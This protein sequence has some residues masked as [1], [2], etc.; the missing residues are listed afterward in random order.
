[1]SHIDSDG[2][3]WDPLLLDEREGVLKLSAE[4]RSNALS[5]FDYNLNSP[6]IRDDLDNL[7]MRYMGHPVGGLWSQKDW[8]G[9]LT[10]LYHRNAEPRA[11]SDMHKWFGEWIRSRDHPV[12]QGAEFLKRVDEESEITYDVVQAFLR[13]WAGVE[14]SIRRKSGEP[15][16]MC[17]SL[18]QK[19]LDLHKMV[20]YLNASTETERDALRRTLGLK[21]KKGFTSG[22]FISLGRVFFEKG[23]CW[24]E[25]QR[26]VMDRNFIL[27][28]KDVIVGRL[29]TVL[30][31]IGHENPV[32]SDG[33]IK[34]FTQIY[35]IGDSILAELGNEAYDLI[36]CIEPICNLRLSELAH[37][38]RPLIPL[39]PRFHQHISDSVDSLAVRST[40]I[41]A[42]HRAIMDLQ[43]VD[44]V[45]AVYGSFRHW[46]HP[47][48][49]YTEGLRKLHEQVTM[50][51]VIDHAYA[52]ALASDLARI[53]LEQE[54]NKKKKW[55]VNPAS[56]SL[57]HPFRTHILENTWPTPAQI[58]DFGDHWHELPLIQCFDIP[59]LIDPS[60]IYSDK[61]H[62]MNRAEVLNHVR[63]HPNKIIPTKKVLKTM[64]EKPATNWLEFLDEI[65]RN[66]LGEDDLVIGLKGKERE[67]KLIGRFFSL[68]SWKLREYFVITE[69]LIKTHFVPLFHGLTMADD[70]TSVIKKMMDS[71]S[72]QGLTDY[73]AVCIANHIDYEKWNNHQRKESNGPVFRVMGQFLGF[74]NLISRTHEFFEKS[75]VYYN[76]RPDLMRVSGNSLTNTTNLRVCWEGQAGGLEGLRQKGWSILNLLVIQREAKIRNTS[77]KVLAQGDNQVICTQYKTRNHRDS[78][79][80][81]SALQDIQSNNDAIMS[82][83]ERGTTKL[84]LVI[85][86]DETMQSA[87]YLNYGKIPIFR[88]T[89]RGLEF[90]RWSRVTCVTNDQLPT[91]ANLMSSVSTNALTVAHFDTNPTNAM[92]QF[93]YFGNFARLLLYMH[94]PAIKLSFHD[95]KFSLK[96]VFS[97]AFKIGML[98][99]DPSIGGVCGTALSRFLIRSFPD[100]VTESLA[101]WKLIYHNTGKKELRVLAARFGNPRIAVFRLE[102]VD[103]LL[104][105]PTSLNISM[106]MSPANLLKTEIKKNL[107]ENKGR[108]KNQIV[109]DSV[110]R[111][112]KDDKHL[113]DFLW[114]IDPLFPRFLSEFKSGTFA[115]VASSIVSLFQNSRTVRNLFKEF[116]S[117]EL[118]ILVWRSEISSLEHLVS[119][120]IRRDTPAIWSCSASQADY[121]RTLS[122][123]RKCLGTTVPH[124]LEMHGRGDIKSILNECCRT[125]SMD[126]ISVYCPKGLTDVLSGR[127]PFPA[128]LGSKTS[129]ST[130]I[131]QPWEKESKVPLIRRATRL[132]DA[133]HWFI[134]PKSNL[135]SAINDN[136]SSLTGEDWSQAAPG[137]KRTGSALHRFSTSRMSNGGFA[138]QSPAA[139]TRMV[140][141]TDTMI[142]FNQEN[143][144]FMFQ[145]SLLYSQMST[146]VMLRD[147]GIS[148]TVHFH[149]K[150]RDC[151]RKIEEPWLETASAYKFDNM[152]TTLNEWRNGTGS[153]GERREQ[154]PLQNGDWES[155]TPAEKSYHVGRAVGFLYGELANQNSKHSDDSSIFPLSIQKKLRGHSFFKGMLDGLM[156]ASACQVIHRRS[157]AQIKRPANAVYGGLIY[158]IDKLSLSHPFVN[159]CREGQL[160]EELRSIPHKIPASYPTSNIDLGVNIRNY[161]RYH[162]A[163][164]SRGIYKIEVPQIWVFSDLMSLDFVGPFALSGKL[165]KVLYKP[166]LSKKDRNSIRRINNL[167]KLLRSNENLPDV[168]QNYIKERVKCC[169]EEIRHACKFGIPPTLS[170]TDYK[171]WGDEDYGRCYP[172]RV[173]FS[174]Q[175]STKKLTMPQRIQNPIVSGLRTAQL[176]TGAHYKLR[177]IIKHFVIRYSH[178]I[179]G[180]DG[181][182]GMTAALLRMNRQSLGIFNSLLDYSASTMRG[183][184]PDPP[185][186]LETLGGE[187]HRCINGDTVWEAPSDLSET[188]TWQYFH[189]LKSE[190]RLSIDLMV[191]DMEVQDPNT[192]ALI[193]QR[194][195]ENL[196][197]L[198][199]PRGTLIYKTYGTMIARQEKGALETFGPLFQDVH[200]T[201]TEYSSAE[202]S[203]VYLVCRGLKGF[204]DAKEVDW[205]DLAYH[206]GKLRCFAGADSEYDRAKSISRRDGMVGVPKEFLPDPIAS[207]GTLMEIAGVP[208]GV[209]HNL[210]ID[211]DMAPVSGLSKA[212]ALCIMLSHHT[213]NTLR[214]QPALPNPPS[215]G[216]VINLGSALCGIGLW[217]SLFYNDKRLYHTC[218]QC[219]RVC[220]PFRCRTLKLKNGKY[221]MEWGVREQLRINKD[222][223]LCD[224]MA[225]IGQWIRCLSRLRWQEG[226]LEVSWVNAFLSGVSAG[227]TVIQTKN[228]TGVFDF[229]KG[230][231]SKEDHSRTLV[232][233]ET[234]DSRDWRE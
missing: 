138:S 183:S 52:N 202:T 161:F 154:V 134:D 219:I 223:R 92:T 31:M 234:I 122:W 114:S 150:C 18:C 116:M 229:L 199:D 174:S 118:D 166:A 136:L 37:S 132:R 73:S 130:S 133:I 46:G 30:A 137:F 184:A 81:H 11:V 12:D 178:F 117:K 67:L 71:S 108:I 119:Y 188:S 220:F 123:K 77:V 90:K 213:V 142:E 85:N 47:F 209:A 63:K 61:S 65:D 214:E 53:V 111:V 16:Y 64:L 176:P 170:G 41:R 24:L 149:V 160:R 98:Y 177:S 171:D 59:D 175:T 156:R 15:M 50:P 208:S 163:R 49:D 233:K 164:V 228:T 230:N 72:G 120:G 76:G 190:R 135:A 144:D 197:T 140:A 27:M 75:L 1:M 210:S 232:T 212:I 221:R 32:W 189:A 62:S 69:H 107:I 172:I 145:A 217:V 84:G 207:L 78:I 4:E 126:Y 146:S 40:R 162:C 181:S 56:V 157:L 80:L 179:C 66:G 148:N 173:E 110:F 95:Q 165:V 3:N 103:K 54:F 45:L 216:K 222:V 29:Q 21:H 218:L 224:K 105:D 58:Q 94:D 26:F 96:G 155:I 231:I 186:A 33:N 48:I 109:R 2:T 194:I 121:L 128:Y 153:W 226:A 38:Y 168:Y 100:P 112:V 124:P 113:T 70:L 200:L 204:V 104:E 227:L 127:G 28:M 158:L 35:D 141:T 22:K 106:G 169:R 139:L 201:Q 5:Q 215:D 115:G 10:L 68:M 83:I 25:S 89:I 43:E 167:S 196:H 131:I 195:R 206:W 79:E 182:G 97:Y 20:L 17:E 82:A 205:E 51:K 87:D 159:F 101:F 60:I 44:I 34:K 8:D 14:S 23:F 192:S 187:R 7:L 203:E 225:A 102:H 129:E 125:S 91:C 55:S 143:Y 74:P 185:S 6:L 13:G 57:N 86:Q 151:I 198:L 88:G 36:K 9:V 42:L 152:S 193:E 191:F 39:F 93:N 211:L 180:G 19:F 99:L 147:T